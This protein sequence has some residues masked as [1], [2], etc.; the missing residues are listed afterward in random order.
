MKFLVGLFCAVGLIPVALGIAMVI[1][2]CVKDLR[3][4]IKGEKR[5]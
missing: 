3:A 4:M 2:Q 5:R 1:I